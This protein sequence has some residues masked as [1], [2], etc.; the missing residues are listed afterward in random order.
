MGKKRVSP[1]LSR[2]Q[3]PDTG[4][5][6]ITYLSEYPP[7]RVLFALLPPFPLPLPLPFDVVLVSTPLSSVRLLYSSTVWYMSTVVEC[8]ERV[9]L[10]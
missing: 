4:Q 3:G 1:R 9:E 5:R 10:V 6:E 2:Q 8:V 7:R